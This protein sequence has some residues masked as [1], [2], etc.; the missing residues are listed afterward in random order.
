M[1]P[2]VSGAVEGSEWSQAHGDFDSGFIM[3]QSP[4]FFE[5]FSFVPTTLVLVASL[6]SLQ[7]TREQMSWEYERAKCKFRKRNLVSRPE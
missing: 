6:L 1:L 4:W 2:K 5:S 3:S 7:L